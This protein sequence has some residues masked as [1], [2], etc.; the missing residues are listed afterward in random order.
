[1]L[2]RAIRYYELISGLLLGLDGAEGLGELVGAG[3]GFG[4][5]TDAFETADHLAGCHSAHE[6]T[7][8]LEV[9]V[10][11]SGKADVFNLAVLAVYLNLARACAAGLVS[12][13]FHCWCVNRRPGGRQAV[14]M[15]CP[16]TPPLC[17]GVRGYW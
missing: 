2:F 15:S 16:R 7:Y 5:A 1:M 4:A 13:G 9:A 6:G 12:V 17:F 11:S 3:G 14:V 8:A 10:A